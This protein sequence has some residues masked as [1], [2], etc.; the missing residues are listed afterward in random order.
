MISPVSTAHLSK[1]FNATTP[2]SNPAAPPARVP[3]QIFFR[4][5]N[6]ACKVSWG[7]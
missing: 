3:V 1:D 2:N 6:R 4:E 7:M 5:P